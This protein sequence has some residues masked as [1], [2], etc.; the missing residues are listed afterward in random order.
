MHTA[1]TCIRKQAGGEGGSGVGGGEGVRQAAGR[2]QLVAWHGMTHAPGGRAA[3]VGREGTPAEVGERRLDEASW[4]ADD[5]TLTS[6]QRTEHKV[7][8]RERGASS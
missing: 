5:V 6:E 8:R 1:A 2:L 7:R 4:Q 3:A